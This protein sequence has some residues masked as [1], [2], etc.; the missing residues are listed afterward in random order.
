MERR[1]LKREYVAVIAAMLLVAAGVL[2]S[3]GAATAGDPPNAVAEVRNTAGTLLGKVKFSPT[4]DGKVLVK[5]ALTGLSPG[6][7][8]FHVH[9]TGTCNP[10]ATD[11][12]GASSPFFTAGGHYNPGATTHGAH[13]GDMPPV[14][15]NGD[16][17]ASMRFETD[18]FSIPTL[19]SGDGSALIV[20]A[21][22]DN[23]AH[24]PASTATGSPR[25]HSHSETDVAYTFGPDLATKAT[26]DAGARFGCGIVS[27]VS[28]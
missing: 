4:D 2:T 25:Y 19:L 9:N 26:G 18:R 23:L 21:G 7:H 20:H 1:S 3:G 27:S 8:G 22:P 14:L 15:V 16:G 28:E 13:G 24:I 17:T 5:L 6:F 12:A 10:T 11:A